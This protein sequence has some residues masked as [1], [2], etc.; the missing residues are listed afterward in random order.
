MKKIFLIAVIAMASAK[1]Y[2]QQILINTL[3]SQL[4]KHNARDSFV[5]NRLNQLAL[6]YDVPVAKRDS[7]A[8]EALK[9]SR[10]I[11]YRAW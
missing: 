9:L 1:M 8:M 3:E 10:Q 5:V 4:A 6:L 7:I 2:G 11:K